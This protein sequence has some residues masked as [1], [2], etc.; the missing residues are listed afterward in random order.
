MKKTAAIIFTA[1]ALLT[2]SACVRGHGFFGRPYGYVTIYYDGYYGPYGGGYWGPDGYFY[3]LDRNQKYVRDM[4]R[5]FRREHFDGS[6]SVRAEDRSHDR[7]R[8]RR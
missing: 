5:H 4:N 7:D 6:R 8:D 3:Y 2:L 1:V